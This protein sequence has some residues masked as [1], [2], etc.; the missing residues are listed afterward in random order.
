MPF[1]LPMYEE[2]ESFCIFYFLTVCYFKNLL[3]KKKQ[4]DEV[5]KL[6]KQ[7]IKKI[8]IKL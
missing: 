2:C 6:K 7:G 4:I 3:K 5:E 1:A 8:K